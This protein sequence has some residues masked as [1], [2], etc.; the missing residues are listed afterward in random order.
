MSVKYGLLG[1]L[2]R[3]PRHGYELKAAFE[4]TAGGFWDVNYG[5]IYSTLDRLV[6]DGLVVISSTEAD[7]GRERKVYSVTEKG[8]RALRQWLAEPVERPRPLRDELF[9]KIALLDA[10]EPEPILKLLEQQRQ[11]YLGQMA[12][13]TRQKMHVDDSEEGPD[14]L[15]TG[16]LVD[17]AL[18]HAEADLRWLDHCEARIHAFTARHGKRPTTRHGGHGVNKRED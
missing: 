2:A 13:L 11:L 6:R 1:M 18:F 3:K 4:E 14:K 17:A 12:R 7:G 9:V 15:I 8:A 5:Q 10:K 16:L